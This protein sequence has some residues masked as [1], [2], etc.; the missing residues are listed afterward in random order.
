[1]CSLSSTHHVHDINSRFFSFYW[2]HTKSRKEPARLA[3]YTHFERYVRC[4]LWVFERLKHAIV[5]FFSYFCCVIHRKLLVCEVSRVC[6]SRLL[7][8][9]ESCEFE[10]ISLDMS[11]AFFCISGFLKS[12]SNQTRQGFSNVFYFVR[13]YSLCFICFHVSLSL[14]FSLAIRTKF[15]LFF[16]IFFVCS[17][18]LTSCHDMKEFSIL[19]FLLVFF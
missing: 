9:R 10:Y 19:N 3:A 18:W 11:G 4:V 13:R 17:Y 1:M 8:P 5:F 15:L 14:S 6:F 2:I 7:V 12:N 16:Y